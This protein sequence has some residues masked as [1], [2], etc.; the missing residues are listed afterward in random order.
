[1]LLINIAG[2]FSLNVIFGGSFVDDEKNDFF[3][4]VCCVMMVFEGFV[5]SMPNF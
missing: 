5:S 3:G 1:V 4:C 2:R